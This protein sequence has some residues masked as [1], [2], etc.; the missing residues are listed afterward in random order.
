M[1]ALPESGV[2]RVACQAL[3]SC[4][5]HVR[6][7]PRARQSRA[8]PVL[9][10]GGQGMGVPQA[11]LRID[12]QVKIDMTLRATFSG[13]HPVIAYKARTAIKHFPELGLVIGGNGPIQ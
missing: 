7:D 11:K 8:N 12:Q 4:R 2:F 6:Y 5:L 1:G 3:G 9:D 13:T 10:V